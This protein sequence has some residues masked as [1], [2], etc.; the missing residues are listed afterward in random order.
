MKDRSIL[1]ILGFVIYI[2]MSAIDKFV[3]TVPD[4]VYIPL[5]ILSIILVVIGAS[6]SKK[7]K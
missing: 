6:K 7:R 1:I 4:A 3:F 2:A 5:G